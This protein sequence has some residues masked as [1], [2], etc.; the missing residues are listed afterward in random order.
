MNSG[1]T[2]VQYNDNNIVVVASNRCGVEP[3]GTCKRW[4]ASDKKSIIV[5][6]PA[7][8]GLYN[9]YMGGVDRLDQ[10]VSAYRV[11]IRMKKWYWSLLMFALNAS[12]N[13]AYQ[14]YRLTPNGRDKGSLDFLGFIRTIVQNYMLSEPEPRTSVGRSPKTGSKRVPEEVR[15]DGVNHLIVSSNTQIRCGHCKKNTTKKCKKC[16]VGCHANCFENFHK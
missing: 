6:Q 13:N 5:P 11:S 8:V 16:N 1:I 3:L 15:L 4:S 2:L 14:I 9:T 7:C 10:N 12:M